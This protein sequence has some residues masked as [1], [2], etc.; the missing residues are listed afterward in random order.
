MPNQS[1]AFDRAADYYDSTRGFPPGVEADVGAL[2]VKAGGLTASSRVL[3]IGVGTGRIAL[4][5]AP[6]IGAYYGIDLARPMLDRL[7]AKQS[8]EPVYAIEGDVTR[9]P[10]PTDAFDAVTAVHIFHLIPAWRAVLDEVARVL[11]R[12]GLLLH[13]WNDRIA[14]NQLQ[15][16]WDQATHDSRATEGAIAWR[17]RETFLEENG[18][19]KRGGVQTHPFTIWRSPAA[20]LESLRERRWSSTWRMSDA[21]L[22]QGLAAVEAAIAEHFPDPNQP[23][24]SESAFHVQAYSAPADA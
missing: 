15:T 23:I 21:E 24:A 14:T 9:L 16:V 12:D 6:H 18:W 17:Q 5:V 4:P 10:F 20:Y 3:E 2:M 13:G 19:H 8:G 11:R 7:R 1:V 22:Q